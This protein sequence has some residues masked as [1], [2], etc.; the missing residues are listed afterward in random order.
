MFI[1][2]LKLSENKSK[3]SE[4]LSGHKTGSN[5]DFLMEYFYSLEVLKQTRVVR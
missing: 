1:V 3:A 5:K 2:L 4:Y